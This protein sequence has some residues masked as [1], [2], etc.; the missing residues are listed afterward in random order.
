M[1]V[2]PQ[3]L[4]DHIIDHV[5]DRDSLKACSLVC[6]Q[7]SARSRKHLFVRVDFTSATDPER[8]CACVRPGPSGPSSLVETLVLSDSDSPPTS[9]LPSRL[10][11]PIFPNAISHF[12]SFSALRVLMI[13][14]RRMTTDR[15]SSM[16]HS[17]GPSLENVTRLTLWHIVIHPATFAMFINHFPRLDDLSIT[18]ISLPR[19]LG[20]TGDSHRETCVEI[21]PT[22]PRGNFRATDDFSACRVP[23]EVFEVITLLEPRFHR[24]S[25]TRVSR[26]MWR[27]YWPLVDEYAGSLEE[28]LILVNGTGECRSGLISISDHMSLT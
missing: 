13:W 8:W 5:G 21:V 24:V 16:F 25:L 23:K 26:D 2:L 6:S 7:W 19:V 11:L 28:L 12:R 22:H 20:P 9:R 14:E 18:S 15:V 10:H 3:E 4:I 17:F 1:P 27:D